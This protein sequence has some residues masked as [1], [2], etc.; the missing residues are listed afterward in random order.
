MVK[1]QETDAKSII[2]T[3]QN[4]IKEDFSDF[5]RNNKFATYNCKHSAKWDLIYT[6]I[7]NKLSEERFIKINM[8]RKIW[9]FIGFIHKETKILYIITR[10]KNFLKIQHERKTRKHPHYIDGFATL[11]EYKEIEAQV[12]LF[13][14]FTEFEE[15]EITDVLNMLG[16]NK[17]FVHGFNVIT[18]EEVSGDIIEV[19]VYEVNARL[20]I[21][22]SYSCSEFITPHFDIDH[23]PVDSENI[24]DGVEKDNEND[25]LAIG[26]K[27]K[28]ETRDA[29]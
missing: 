12:E 18:F 27:K 19:E 25:D 28:K 17:D 15:N 26:I 5:K 8:S 3:I 24:N 1:L 22:D 14:T 16:E 7:A 6:N 13:D 10:K 21:T 2:Q 4:G 29:K 20:N 23:E 9:D 11:N